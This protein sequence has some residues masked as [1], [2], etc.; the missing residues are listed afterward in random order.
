M[1][2]SCDYGICGA[3]YNIVGGGIMAS[4]E[5]LV[6]AIKDIEEIIGTGYY[7][8]EGDEILSHILNFFKSRLDK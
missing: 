1:S 2:K 7:D 8:G 6:E 3:A 5:E 4:R